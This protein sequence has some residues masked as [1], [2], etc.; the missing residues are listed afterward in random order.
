[1]RL[2]ATDLELLDATLAWT[3]GQTAANMT[4]A[5]SFSIV[6][7]SFMTHLSDKGKF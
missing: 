3:L 7:I 4:R 6:S 1:M 5:I 2:P